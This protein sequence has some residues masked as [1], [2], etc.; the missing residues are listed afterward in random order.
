MGLE[1]IGGNLQE[2]SGGQLNAALAATK[3]KDKDMNKKTKVLVR[4]DK[5]SV[6]S[7]AM[8]ILEK[9]FPKKGL[10]AVPMGAGKFQIL[11]KKGEIFG[12]FTVEQKA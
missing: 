3:R 2:L 10:R 6:A 11:D 4:G 12:T 8:K 7:E 9:A 1:G 5:I